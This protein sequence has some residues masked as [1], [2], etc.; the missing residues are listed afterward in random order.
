MAY[1]EFDQYTLDINWYFTDHYNRICIAASAGGLLPKPIVENDEG[2][3][4]FHKIINELPI[5]F[6][7]TRNETVLDL[8]QGISNQ[9]LDSYFQDFESLAG[10]GLYVFDKL[11]LDDPEDGYYLLV[12]YPNYDTNIDRYPVDKKNLSLIPKT[13]Q[14][15]ISRRNQKVLDSNFTPINLVHILNSN[16]IR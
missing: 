8:L 10:R 12:A 2:N 16:N 4:Q 3:E 14:S 11:K 13:K 5:R 9:N 1:N 7:V 6:E 15:I